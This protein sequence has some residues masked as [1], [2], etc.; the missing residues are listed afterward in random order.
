MAKMEIKIEYFSVHHAGGAE[1]LAGCLKSPV[2][3]E[4]RDLD[5]ISALM[6]EGWDLKL[7]VPIAAEHGQTKGIMHYFQR[8]V[9]QD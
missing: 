9:A 3:F 4:R 7:V 5:K 1:Q 8:E 6:E 2:L